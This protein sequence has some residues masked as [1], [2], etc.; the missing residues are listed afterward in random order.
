MSMQGSAATST[1]CPACIQGRPRSQGDRTKETETVSAKQQAATGLPETGTTGNIR[2]FLF[3]KWSIA[4]I[5]VFRS[6]REG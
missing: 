5:A 3:S 4:F 1:Q 6:S 2:L